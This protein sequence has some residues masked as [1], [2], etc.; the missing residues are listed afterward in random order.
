MEFLGTTRWNLF[1]GV[2]L[3]GFG[4]FETRRKLTL[5]FSGQRNRLDGIFRDLSMEF[6]RDVSLTG[7]S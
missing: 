4:R 7:F 5:D 3:T 1:G 6:I 2:L